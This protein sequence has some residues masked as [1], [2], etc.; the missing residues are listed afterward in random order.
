MLHVFVILVA[1]LIVV[2]VVKSALATATHHYR[3]L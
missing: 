1:T 3:R 2:E